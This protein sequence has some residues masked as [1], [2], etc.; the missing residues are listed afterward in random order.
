MKRE[1]FDELFDS[2]HIVQGREEF[3]WLVNEVEK[4]D[5]HAIIEIGVQYGGSLK[6]WERLVAPGDLVIGVDK[7]LETPNL[8]TWDHE[9]S[10]RRVVL[11]TGD[12]VN[13]DTERRVKETLGGREADFLYINGDHAFHAVSNDFKNYSPF[14][15]RGGLVGFH[16][17]YTDVKNPKKVFDTLSGRKE[18]RQLGGQGT[19]LWWK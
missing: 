14:V 17:L 1:V 3:R 8:M 15:R 4:I 9:S 18:E 16:D 13:P 19:G 2:L 12:S 7:N 5:P 10:D 6:F 11:I